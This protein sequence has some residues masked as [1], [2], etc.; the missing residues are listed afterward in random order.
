[1]AGR[2]DRESA[3]EVWAGR[4]AAGGSEGRGWV[5]GTAPYARVTLLYPFSLL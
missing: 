1:L 2:S 3:R 5:L 4:K